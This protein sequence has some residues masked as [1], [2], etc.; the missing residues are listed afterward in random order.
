MR[1]LC[2]GT[3]LLGRA[4]RNRAGARAAAAL[5]NTSG[6][7]RHPEA[8]RFLITSVFRIPG[9]K[10]PT[11]THSTILWVAKRH[12]YKLRQ[13]RRLRIMTDETAHLSGE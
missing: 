1:G 3:G 4:S 10:N 8:A 7:L 9:V 13:W 12:T 2:T 11:T 6:A 5:R